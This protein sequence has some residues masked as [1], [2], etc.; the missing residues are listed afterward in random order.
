MQSWDMYELT[1]TNIAFLKNE[2]G[3]SGLTYS[4]L[5]DELIDHV[6]CDVEYEMQ[7]GLPFEKA[8]EQVKQRIGLEGL[9]RIQEDT[10]LLINKKYRIMKSTMRIFGVV[11]TILL[12]VG[13][14]FKI[15]HWPG[16]GILLTLGFF[17]LGTVFLPSAVYVNYCEVSNK[18]RRWT[19]IAGFLSAFFIAFGFL[20]KIQ[21]WP[22][23]GIMITIGILIAI[24]FFIPSVFYQKVKEAKSAGQTSFFVLAMIGGVLYL[25][26]LLFKIQHW[27]GAALLLLA[28][29]VITV[30]V[31]FT[32]HTYTTY[33][34]AESVSSRFIF[35][36]IAVVL[37]IV[38]TMLLS[39]N[40]SQ[41]ALNVFTEI[42]QDAERNMEHITSKNQ[43]LY[44]KL[45]ANTDA[46]KENIREK[47]MSLQKQSDELVASIQA[48]KIQV[49]TANEG[50]GNKQWQDG[51]K[52][53]AEA[54]HSTEIN[55][56][57]RQILLGKANDGEVS[58]IA[59][60]LSEYRNYLIQSFGHD[61]I[62]N[63]LLT[64]LLSPDLTDRETPETKETGFLRSYTLIPTLHK[65]TYI[66]ENVR[67][68]E[69]IA[70]RAMLK[71]SIINQVATK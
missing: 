66:Q 6:C 24:L 54:L 36:T 4:H 12:A 16:A 21:H 14:L 30:G 18:T 38:P 27:P 8:Y 69:N 47:A 7:K 55:D 56:E 2:V 50:P 23:A 71:T 59:A 33:K 48:L 41:N 22:A 1:N 13:T 49:V 3:R 44:G 63:T 40:L 35:T 65:L 67:T 58:T 62:T 46:G 45:T 37:L 11:S 9:Q 57:A 20:F 32:I 5:R 26:G 17:L 52:I 42:Q 70:L 53:K 39:V 31:V 51:N 43:I 68:A 28:G 15:E 60:K 10:L 25:A 64:Q 29:S 34:N 61:S 19:H